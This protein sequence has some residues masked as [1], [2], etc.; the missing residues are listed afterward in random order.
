[1]SNHDNKIN[2]RKYSINMQENINKYKLNQC[3]LV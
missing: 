2:I 1:M 3:Y